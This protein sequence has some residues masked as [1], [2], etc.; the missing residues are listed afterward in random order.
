MPIYGTSLELKLT[1]VLGD[2]VRNDN[3]AESLYLYPIE[4]E[5]DDVKFCGTGSTFPQL[6]TILKKDASHSDASKVIKEVLNLVGDSYQVEV[7][8]IEE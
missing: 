7:K 1:L 3:E 8:F 2:T 6:V 5:N 4:S